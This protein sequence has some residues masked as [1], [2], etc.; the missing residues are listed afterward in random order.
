MPSRRLPFFRRVIGIG[1]GLFHRFF[2]FSSY[3]TI[4]HG[5]SIAD[6]RTPE[7]LFPHMFVFAYGRLACRKPATTFRYPRLA[8]YRSFCSPRLSTRQTGREA[9]RRC[10]SRL[11][12]RDMG[13]PRIC[14]C[15]SRYKLTLYSIP[16][17]IVCKKKNTR[18]AVFF[19]TRRAFYSPICMMGLEQGNS[20][21]LPRTTLIQEPSFIPL[22]VRTGY[23]YYIEIRRLCR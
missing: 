4:Y 21:L 17:V 5:N 22:P 20:N 10:A 1:G 12:I 19:R 2:Y 7:K 11:S 23:V 3:S 14:Y 15:V 18:R 9:Y 8:R 13:E 6:M 16:D